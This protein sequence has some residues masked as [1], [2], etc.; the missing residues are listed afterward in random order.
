MSAAVHQ[1]LEFLSRL[2]GLA[3]HPLALVVALALLAA[4]VEQRVA[5]RRAADVSGAWRGIDGPPPEAPKLPSVRD[6]P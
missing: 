1:G 3:T 2:H 5:R 4:L 6:R